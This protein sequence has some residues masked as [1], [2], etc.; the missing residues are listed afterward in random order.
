MAWVFP[1]KKNWLNSNGFLTLWSPKKIMKTFEVKTFL[2]EIPYH[3]IWSLVWPQT[4]MM[5]CTIVISLTDMWAAGQINNDI[6]AGIGIAAQLQ[7]FFMVVGTSIGAGAM[8]AVTQSLGAKNYIKAKRYTGLVFVFALGMSFFISFLGYIFRYPIMSALQVPDNILDLSITFYTFILCCLPAQYIMY[9]SAILFRANSNVVTPLYVALLVTSLNVFGDLTFG[10]GYFG[11]PAYGGIGIMASSLVAVIIGAIL[12]FY[13]MVKHKLFIHRIIPTF[14]WMKTA[15]PYLLKVSIPAITMQTLWQLGYLTLF[16]IMAALP[17]SVT[18]LAG[19]S[20]GMRLESILFMPAVAFNATASIMVGNAIGA[21]NI[22]EA[23]KLGLAIIIFGS[24]L[25]SFVGICMY[26]FVDVLASAFT[27]NS[28]TK[29]N[30]VN[31]LIINIASTP[32]T[33]GGLIVS[34]IFVGAGA[35]IYSLFINP[36]C[37]WGI[38]LPLAWFLAHYM[39][40]GSVGVYFA[41]LISMAIQASSMFYIF[42]TKNWH[43]HAMKKEEPKF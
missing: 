26:P 8:A 22:Q 13:L 38:R 3:S 18:A 10:L 21:G 4:V 25:M 17:N 12:A 1:P 5:L 33:V 28:D 2:S 31:Y 23:K 27:D 40:Y 32:F 34:G 30:I 41:M 43:S 29:T 42:L 37:I 35:T 15:I 19:L 6:Q 9:L 24:A 20:S 7:A 16:G 36:F 11:F 14:S 39:A